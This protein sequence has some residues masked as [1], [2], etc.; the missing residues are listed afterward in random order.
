MMKD[1]AICLLE[2]FRLPTNVALKERI[3][4]KSKGREKPGALPLA[5]CRLN[6]KSVRSTRRRKMDKQDDKEKTLGHFC[7]SM[8]LSH[9][10]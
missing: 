9:H 3:M 1:Y 4:Y 2:F 8:N 7:R 10:Y 5:V 6:L